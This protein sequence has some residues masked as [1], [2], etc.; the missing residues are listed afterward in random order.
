MT[1]ILTHIGLTI[2]IVVSFLVMLYVLQLVLFNLG[3]TVPPPTGTGD[4]N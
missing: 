2:L 4:T 1:W 3:G